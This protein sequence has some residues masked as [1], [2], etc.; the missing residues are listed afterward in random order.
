MA[1][2]RSLGSGEGTGGGG[3][4][5]GGARARA[6]GRGGVAAGGGRAREGEVERGARGGEGGGG[7]RASDR[8][9]SPE[10]APAGPRLGYLPSGGEMS[11]GCTPC[12]RCG[13]EH[14]PLIP[15]RA[16]GLRSQARYPG[17]GAGLSALRSPSPAE[18]RPRWRVQPGP[19]RANTLGHF[20]QGTSPPR[21]LVSSAAKWK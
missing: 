2:A 21:V 7:A 13:R 8:R 15:T 19:L 9:R 11:G 6:R 18:C 5:A 10:R 14:Q 20:G 4:A 17:A 1:A 12:P 16:P 3:V